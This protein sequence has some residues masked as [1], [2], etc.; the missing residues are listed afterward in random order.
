[1][2]QTQEAQTRTRTYSWQDPAPSAS[3]VGTTS[4]LEM[5]Q[6]IGDGRLPGPPVG[7]TLGM[8][9]IEVERGRVVFAVVP[10]EWHANPIGTVHGGVL[11]TLLDSAAACAVHSTLPAGTAYTTV[12]L[13]ITYVR[14]VTTATGELRCEGTVLSRGSRTALA[15]AQV[16]DAEGRLVA[17][18]TSTCLLMPLPAR[19]EQRG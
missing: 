16:R 2:L 13:N 8:T 6:A 11:A 10:Q 17:H 9:W 19:P 18:A 7:D 1:M 4:G 12:D 5:L 15:Q 14:S 3:A